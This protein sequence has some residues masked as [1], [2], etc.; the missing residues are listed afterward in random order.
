MKTAPRYTSRN[1]FANM[2]ERRAK[3]L[4]ELSERIRQAYEDDAEA[5]DEVFMAADDLTVAAKWL[6]DPVRT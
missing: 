6:R 4:V 1:Q 3:E 2:L 5:A